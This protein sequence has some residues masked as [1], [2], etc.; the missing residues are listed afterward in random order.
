MRKVVSRLVA[1]RGEGAHL[2]L[3]IRLRVRLVSFLQLPHP[4]PLQLKFL[5]GS[6]KED[7][8]ARVLRKRS[9]RRVLVTRSFRTASEESLANGEE[10]RGN[11]QE[12]GNALATSAFA[13]LVTVLT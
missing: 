10:K 6:W 2:E 12:I 8:S 9:S 7:V 11:W 1:E 3:R 13:S 4:P 5:L